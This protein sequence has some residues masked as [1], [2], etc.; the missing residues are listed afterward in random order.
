MATG[1]DVD[2][3]TIAIAKRSPFRCAGQLV[4]GP[5][6]QRSIFNTAMMTFT[7]R[8]HS[9]AVTPENMPF[10][11]GMD[12]MQQFFAIC[13]FVFIN[14][15][16][17]EFFQ[18][19]CVYRKIVR[20]FFSCCLICVKLHLRHKQTNT[21]YTSVCVCLFVLSAVSVRDVRPMAWRSAMLHRNLRGGGKNPGS[22]NKYA[23]FRQLIIRKI[24]IILP[25]GVSC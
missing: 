4:P 12:E 24:I 19:W 11:S 8:Q 5:P 10:V 7:A 1:W 13:V 21:L 20:A 3:V 14:C 6:R 18:H 22:T 2:N 9:C 17:I 23:K 15:H 25:P 16:S